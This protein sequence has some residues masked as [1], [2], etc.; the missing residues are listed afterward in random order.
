MCLI[1]RWR[2]SAKGLFDVT[3]C[4]GFFVIANNTMN[5]Y[6]CIKRLLSFCTFVNDDVTEIRTLLAYVINHIRKSG[7]ISR[8]RINR[9]VR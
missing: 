3:L 6:I 8:K 1:H 7:S 2:Q 5:I 9:Y 4:Q